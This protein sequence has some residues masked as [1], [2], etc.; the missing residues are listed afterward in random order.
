MEFSWH[1]N[2]VQIEYPKYSPTCK[3]FY[4]KFTSQSPTCNVTQDVK[5]SIFRVQHQHKHIRSWSL[6][7]YSQSSPAPHYQPNW[8]AKSTITSMQITSSTNHWHWPQSQTSMSY[9]CLLDI[10]LFIGTFIFLQPN[11][12]F[13]IGASC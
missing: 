10:S 7:I 13:E 3:S 5:M 11:S 1:L 4:A 9:P 12:S 6:L 2:V 8:R